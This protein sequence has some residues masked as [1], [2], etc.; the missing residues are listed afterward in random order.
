MSTRRNKKIGHQTKKACKIPHFFVFLLKKSGIGLLWLIPPLF[1]LLLIIDQAISFSMRSYIYTDLNQ[2][3][4]RPYG[5]VLGTSKYFK[6][7]SINL[8]YYNRLLTAHEIFKENKVDY[9][10]LSGD[11]RTIQ[12]NE[13]RQMT[14]DLEKMGVPKEFLYSD[15]AG[16]RTLDSVIRANEIFQ[17]NSFTIISQRFHCERA[18]FIARH[19]DMD[20]VC[21]VAN[22]PE[23][24]PLVRLREVLARVQ[25]IW[26]ILMKK[27]PHFLGNPEPLPPPIMSSWEE[28]SLPELHQSEIKNAE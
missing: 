5:L 1:L 25:V 16:F 9:L 12:Y 14:K 15:Y 18:L 23:G 17:L 19:Y 10:L 8:F 13:P 28:T 27:Q 21:F 22:N 6:D 11:N 7:R 24:Y 26:D 4:H 20:A 2:L 3:P